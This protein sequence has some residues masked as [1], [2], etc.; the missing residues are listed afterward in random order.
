MPEPPSR[1]L[2]PVTSEVMCDPVMTRSGI[3]YERAAILEWIRLRS[4]CPTTRESLS[5]NDVFPNRALAEEISEWRRAAGVP[6]PAGTTAEAASG[7]AAAAAAKSAQ[8]PDAAEPEPEPAAVA[9][10]LGASCLVAGPADR[11]KELCTVQLAV[12]GQGSRDV[13][14]DVWNDAMA[15]AAGKEGTVQRVD[16]GDGTV[17]VKL[18][19]RGW[20]LPVAALTSADGSPFRWPPTRQDLLAKKESSAPAAAG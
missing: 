12:G 4:T 8:V 16:V 15:G 7:H 14:A 1:F 19:P 5:A 20:W 11:L 2:C 10:S 3:N 13:S 6:A 18:E 17:F 9:L